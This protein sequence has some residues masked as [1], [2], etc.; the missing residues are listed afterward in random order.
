[1]LIMGIQAPNGEKNLSRRAFPEAPAA[2]DQ[3]LNA[4][5]TEG[6]EGWSV[7]TVGDRH[8]LDLKKG[9]GW[10]SPRDQSGV[11]VLRRPPR[12]ER[13]VPTLTRCKT[14]PA[15]KLPFSPRRH[16]T[17]TTRCLW[18]SG[19][20]RQAAA[21]LTRLEGEDWTLPIAGAPAAHPNGLIPTAPRPT[22]MSNYRPGLGKSPQGSDLSLRFRRRMSKD[23]PSCSRAFQLVPR[24]YIAATM[25]PSHGRPR[26]ASGPLRPDPMAM[27]LS[28]VLFTNMAELL[29]SIGSIVG[30]RLSQSARKASRRSNLVP[31]RR[32]PGNVHLARLRP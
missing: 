23:L 11:G 32:E 27:C 28:A 29:R 21:H 31:P 5:A 13:A 16:S 12:H 6:F 19:N 8:S 14:Y 7:N 9:A 30:R 3:S 1:M 4:G 10:D 2:K 17:G 15:K 25:V 20:D 18:W 22:R 24:F 26:S